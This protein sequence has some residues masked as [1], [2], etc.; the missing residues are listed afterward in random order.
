MSSGIHRPAGFTKNA[1]PVR[2]GLGKAPTLLEKTLLHSWLRLRNAGVPKYIPRALKRLARRLFLDR[3]VTV[4]IDNGIRLRSPR[5]A[6]YLLSKSERFITHEFKNSIRPGTLVLDIGA[7][8]GI[9][10]L[11]AANRVGSA[12]KVIAVEPNPENLRLLDDNVR[13]NKFDRIV[14][15]IP[16]AASNRRET[17][18][19]FRGTRSMESSLHSLDE[20]ESVIS[21]ECVRLDEAVGPERV[22]V[23][24]L[25][26][27]GHEIEALEGMEASIRRSDG[28]VLF[29]ECNPGALS[30]AGHCVTDLLQRLLSHGCSVEWAEVNFRNETKVV[31]G[32]E[33]LESVH[34]DPSWHNSTL[35]CIRK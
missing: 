10:T 16:N 1:T 20:I 33:F 22:A 26:V 12:G 6:F 9:Y 2:R 29:I 32:K 23:I 24:K 21:V 17:M 18:R 19:L 11:L 30:R 13:Y 27:E 14:Q 8:V 35:K 34:G 25:D 15:V 28:L 7:H 4:E 3:V 5:S 31:S